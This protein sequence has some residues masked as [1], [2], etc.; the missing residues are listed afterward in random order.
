[1]FVDVRRLIAGM[2]PIVN[3]L[4]RGL[5]IPRIT[6]RIENWRL[7][8]FRRQHFTHL[9][10]TGRVAGER[11]SHILIRRQ[12]TGDQLWHI[13]CQQQAR[14]DPARETLPGMGQ[15]RQTCV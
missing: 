5:E 4:I 11:H 15:Q 1:M 13:D 6:H 7:Q 3:G 2:V 8:T 12:G 9:T 10:N 14:G